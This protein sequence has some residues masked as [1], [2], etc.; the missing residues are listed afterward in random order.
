M[1]DRVA[2]IDV[3]P[4]KIPRDT[5]YLGPLEAGVQPSE[6]GYFIRPG[7][8]TV[9]SIHDHSVLIKLTTEA[10]VVGWGESFGVVSPETVTTIIQNLM[11]PLVRG[12][13]PHDVVAISEDISNAMRVR[14]VFGGF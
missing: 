7:N 10:G 5:P 14:G 6:R 3:F 4:L 9:Y 13:D 1:T 8:Q 12:R 11:L 2:T